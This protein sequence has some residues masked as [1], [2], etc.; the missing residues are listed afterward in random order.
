MRRFMTQGIGHSEAFANFNFDPLVRGLDGEA[1]IHFAVLFGYNTSPWAV[2]D[3]GDKTAGRLQ[4]K[5][6]A[7]I[8]RG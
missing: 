6:G 3:L 8:W 1:A 5:P 4:R 7:S 2:M